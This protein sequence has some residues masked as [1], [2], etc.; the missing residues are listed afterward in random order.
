MLKRFVVALAGVAVLA[1]VAMAIEAVAPAA[2]GGQGAP[3][4][5][6]GLPPLMGNQAPAVRVEISSTP[7]PSMGASSIAPSDAGSYGSGP[8]DERGLIM[9]TPMPRMTPRN[10]VVVPYPAPLMNAAPQAGVVGPYGVGL[11]AAA[12]VGTPYMR[13]PAFA[14]PPVI[15]MPQ[16]VT[17]VLVPGVTPYPANLMQPSGYGYASA[18]FTRTD[19]YTSL[20]YGSFYW[21]RGYAGTTPVEPQIPAYVQI[22]PPGL[23]TLEADSNVNRYKQFEPGP[24]GTPVA[25]PAAANPA[26]PASSA[27]LP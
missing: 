26:A 10:A 9:T 16:V 1:N 5:S 17:R 4:S 2:R 3:T 27:Q 14:G 25:A 18:P 24:A 15:Y 12:P 20:P 7:V 22:A 19:L 6:G 21:P 13:S 23:T 11:A 8:M